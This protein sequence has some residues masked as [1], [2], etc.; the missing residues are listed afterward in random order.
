MHKLAILVL[1]ALATGCSSTKQVGNIVYQKIAFPSVFGPYQA[2]IVTY[3]IG[4]TNLQQVLTKD[5]NVGPGTAIAGAAIQ[6]GGY[7]AGQAARRPNKNTT[8]VQTNV[9]SDT[10][11]GSS[12]DIEID[13]ESNH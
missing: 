13:N 11:V 6:A 7:V 12:N 5:A 8:K 9:D 10:S 2:V 4:K 1:L 3:P